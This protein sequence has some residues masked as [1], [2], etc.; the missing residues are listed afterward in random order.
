M[1]IAALLLATKLTPDV[2]A[3]SLESSPADRTPVLH[4]AL[5][6]DDARVRA[7]AARIVAVTEA[8]D[9][10]D[11]VRT[12][13]ARETSPEAAREEVRA[14]GIN[15]GVKE[16]D[17]LLAQSKRFDSK[18]DA[19]AWTAVARGGGPA[20]IGE[21]IARKSDD[22]SVI[23]YAM[24]GHAELATPTSARILGQSNV[25]M[26]R[27]WL[28]RLVEAEIPLDQQVASAA[29]ASPISEI[30]GLTA[31]N[32]ASELRWNPP[33]DPKLLLDALDRVAD[34]YPKASVADSFGR[35]LL[36]RA[37]GRKARERDEWTQFVATKEAKYKLYPVSHLLTRAERIAA[38][39]APE[40]EVSETKKYA[41]PLP[42]APFD[43]MSDLPAGLAEGVLAAT[44]CRGE[45]IGVAGVA[46]DHA[47]RVR[48]LDL[49]HIG[50]T[51]QCV[52]AIEVLMRSSLARN[53]TINSAFTANDILLV[54]AASA[55]LCIDESPVTGA[56]EAAFRPEATITPP[57]RTSSVEPVYPESSR[58]A[59]VSGIVIIQC[60]ISPSG[61]LHSLKILKPLTAE[62]NTA[63]LI[64]VSQWHF[65]PG[66]LDGKPVDVI[67]NLTV[68]F[69][70]V[71]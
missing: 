8:H 17:S 48:Q 6:D 49:S 54:H 26:W 59:R 65:S 14:I 37:L 11:D 46:V 44:G 21:M 2:V 28:R 39:Y 23:D 20:T 19:A 64:A 67:Y 29:L 62:L 51:K 24:W 61:C 42:P 58:I 34:A 9:L 47:G 33:S 60:I 38:G 56:T 13:L 10:V 1:I 35:E 57:K 12:A 70:L 7:A 32:L 50:A 53:V 15:G 55:D 25:A 40:V 5:S 31:W 43:V 3:M 16:L 68:N 41:P 71:R 4:A 22:Y 66:M 27:A 45:W 30:S 69:K 36:A 52:R 18:L 63:A